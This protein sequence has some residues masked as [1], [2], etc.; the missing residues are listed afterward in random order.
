MAGSG[1]LIV[2]QYIRDAID[3]KRKG[4]PKDFDFVVSQL[5]TPQDSV[6]VGRWLQGLDAC[7]PDLKKE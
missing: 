2:A 6:T 1:A 3:K 5:V 7:T 4:L